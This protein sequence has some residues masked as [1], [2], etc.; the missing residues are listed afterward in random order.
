MKTFLKH[1]HQM[2]ENAKRITTVTMIEWG[3]ASTLPELISALP[4]GPI[5]SIF[6]QTN[7]MPNNILRIRI[8]INFLSN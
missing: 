6:S 2:I 8:R 4:I 5:D 3:W 1:I 7:Q